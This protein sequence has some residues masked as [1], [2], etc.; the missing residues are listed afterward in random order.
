MRTALSTILLA[1]L[2]FGL[3]A[4]CRNKF[5]RV[6]YETVYVGQDQHSVHKAIGRPDKTVGDEWTYENRRPFYRAVLTFEEGVVASKD[7]IGSKD[8]LDD[9]D[10]PATGDD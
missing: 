8:M 2:A 7:W 10:E 9:S 3:A 5:T 4:G 6:N 1:A